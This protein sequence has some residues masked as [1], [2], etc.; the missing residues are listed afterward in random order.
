MRLS[1]KLLVSFYKDKKMK[2]KEKTREQLTEELE[3]LRRRVAELEAT[4]TKHLAVERVLQQMEQEK[5]TILDS[6]VEHVIFHDMEMRVQWANRAA[7]DSVNMSRE[8]LVGRHCYELWPKRTEAC[9][10]CP[11]Q[12]ARQTGQPQ[13]I[14]KTTQD[15]RSWYIK[16]SPVLD[17]NGHFVGMVELTLDITERKQAE[18]G[19][20]QVH[21][22][23]ENRVEKRTADLV[24]AN[25]QLRQEIRERKEAEEQLGRYKLIVS[26]VQDPM[27]FIDSNYIYRTVNDAYTE[28]FERPREEIIGRTVAEM[29]GTEIFEKQIK[30][31]FDR[32]LTGEETHYRDWLDFPDGKRRCMLIN[33]YPFFENDKSVSG[34]IVRAHDMTDLELA[35]EALR[36]SE[37]TLNAILTASPMGI[38][39]VRNRILDWTNKAMYRMWGY[40]VDSLLGQSTEVIYP[41]AEEYERVG[42]DFY[43]E[44]E[45]W[46]IGQV[47][48][49]W[50]TKDGRVI[51]CYL[52]GSP[53]DSSDISKGVI[54]AAMDITER[55]QTEEHVRRLS[56]EVI[57][58]QE[59]ERQKLAADLHDRLAQDLAS[60][61]VGLDTLYGDQ[62]DTEDERKQKVTELSRLLEHTLMA[63]RDKAYGLHP[64]SLKEFGLAYTVQQYCEE[65][66]AKNSLKVDFFSVGMDDLELDFDTEIAFYRLVQEGLTNIRKHADASQVVVRLSASFSHIMLHIED[67]GKGFEVKNRLAAALDERRM[68]IWSMEQRVAFLNGEMKIESD[69]LRGTKIL[70]KIPHRDETNG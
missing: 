6:L 70:I 32:C 58:A 34:L 42:R 67:N 37:R 64:P 10:D 15:G 7:C 2:D 26:A 4:Q 69:P 59:V 24:R 18:E 48:T 62:P 63:V 49:R 39:L 35:Q 51:D 52:Q 68:G 16:G 21:D 47:E 3:E 29:F 22:E 55:K 20:R 46:G 30:S 28:I 44:I 53:L 17:S 65:F 19:L 50:L 33:Y 43:S 11:V 5:Q 38:G 14:E 61:K 40:E 9:E 8:E 60:L 54:L 13:A 23:L 31:H 36:E 57:K 25:E 12:L 66:A 56:Q 1:D 27:S 45:K 41:H